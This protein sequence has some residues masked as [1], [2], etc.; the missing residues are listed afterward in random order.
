MFRAMQPDGTG[1]KLGRS[2]RCL[3]VVPGPKGDIE[4]DA[5]GQVHPA[6]GGM[7]VAPT[8]TDLPIWRVPQRLAS[9]IRGASGANADRIWS[10]GNQRFS[11]APIASGLRL[12][13]DRPGHGNV[14]PDVTCP[15]NE[16]EMN[17]GATRSSWVVDEP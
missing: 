10:L 8:W 11:D 1:P 15:F 6:T 12:R 5:S 17:L 13:V 9:K 3:G 14:E 4:P 7:S 16:F 2:R